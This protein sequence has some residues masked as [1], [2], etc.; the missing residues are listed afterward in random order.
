MTLW[1]EISTIP[2]YNRACPVIMYI[3][4]CIS[5]RAEHNGQL[6]TFNGRAALSTTRMNTRL[7]L[8]VYALVVWSTAGTSQAFSV[9]VS[10]NGTDASSCIAG[11]TPCRSLDYVLRALGN[12]SSQ[13]RSIPYD[14]IV[15][16]EYGSIAVEPSKYT[17]SCDLNLRIKGS[18]VNAPSAVCLSEERL[19]FVASPNVSLSMQWE[20]FNIVNCS[21]PQAIGLAR[22]S[23]LTCQ[24]LSSKGIYIQDTS[25]VEIRGSQFLFIEAYYQDASFVVTNKATTQLSITD[26][27]FVGAFPPTTTTATLLWVVRSVL[28]IEGNVTFT[29]SLGRLGG[30]VRLTHSQVVAV[31]S[32]FVS[33]VGNRAEYGSGVYIEDVV[34]PLLN[35]SFGYPNFIF[36]NG[37]NTGQTI[38]YIDGDL[39]GCIGDRLT[40]NLSFDKADSFIAT[41][42]TN[43]SIELPE[44][45]DVFP[46]KDVILNVI[47]KDFF[48][49]AAICSA[50]VSMTVVDNSKQLN[51]SCNDPR[52]QV[53]LICPFVSLSQASVVLSDM[54]G[55]NSTLHI[56]TASELELNVTINFACNH[57][58][59]P[60]ASVSLTVQKCPPFLT[61][62]SNIS[63]SCECVLPKSGAA[64][65]I[66]SIQLGTFC[67]ES[68]FWAGS[69]NDMFVVLPCDLPYCFPQSFCPMKGCK[70]LFHRLSQ[71]PDDQCSTHHG[72]LL[73]RGCR[74]GYFFTHYPL[75]CVNSCSTGSSFGILMA[76][77]II[78]I[79]KSLAAFSII[80][81]A[82]RSGRWIQLSYLYSSFVYLHVMGSLPLAYME[83]YKVLRVLVS[84]TRSIN[85]PVLDVMGEIPVCFFSSIGPLGIS[86]LQYTGPTVELVLLAIASGCSFFY[87]NRFKPMMP[88][89][90][91]ILLLWP[92]WEISSISIS[93]FKGKDLESFDSLRVMLQPDLEYLSGP[94]LSIFIIATLLLSFLIL[95]CCIMFLASLLPFKNSVLKAP[96]FEGF[97]SSYK[98]KR[99]WFSVVYFVFWLLISCV[100]E[101]VS[102]YLDVYLLLLII[103]CSGHYL[104]WP[105]KEELHNR[106][107]MAT[108]LNLLVIVSLIRQ[109]THY[110]ERRPFAT[111][112]VYLFVSTQIVCDFIIIATLLGV[113]PKH[114]LIPRKVFHLGSKYRNLADTVIDPPT[115]GDRF[116]T[117][118]AEIS[119][120]DCV[121]N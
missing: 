78:H 83:E 99:E 92:M 76:S 95:P 20:S 37:P 100:S 32:V 23:F 3:G 9:S 70:P 118:Y 13:L 55:A 96:V 50:N 31:G 7:L 41:A 45:F 116:E 11:A 60:E 114:F 62:Y 69:E 36:Q 86:A 49:N 6:N 117:S 102:E 66:C 110:A 5:F 34:C 85:L 111:S 57:G 16:V 26:S 52:Y 109:Q 119:L 8:F 28:Q 27:A 54:T 106:I 51:I 74:D 107:D 93:I 15:G 103:L 82:A 53:E 73:C 65:L 44:N 80:S 104:V 112:C 63:R 18:A 48:Q 47:L 120:K 64:H 108:L 29:N 67:I 38:V 75:Q 61:S 14:V 33:F 101:N 113:S 42:A 39:N 79:L 24:F 98:D 71:Y 94:H 97:R 58:E 88:K 17:F 91:G 1:E 105:Y 89:S 84:I 77:L 59:G 43:F 30:A 35:T 121:L 56:A 12:C 68:G 4:V 19:T 87:P 40:Y 2:A 81:F 115:Q 72:G 25:H 21:G 22:L 90:I 10:P 46:G